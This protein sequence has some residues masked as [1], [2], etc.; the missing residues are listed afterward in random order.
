MAVAESRTLENMGYARMHVLLVPGVVRERLAQKCRDVLVGDDVLDGGND[1]TTGSLENVFV[2][3]VRVVF[4]DA[5]GDDVVPPEEEDADGEEGRV[6]VG[7]GVAQ[8]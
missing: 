3:P 7:S 2:G 8:H 4:L 6:L 1:D 5:V